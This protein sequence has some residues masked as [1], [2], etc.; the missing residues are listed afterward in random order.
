MSNYAINMIG[1]LG[2]VL[3]PVSQF[4]FLSFSNWSSVLRSQEYIKDVFSLTF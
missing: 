1:S 2:E 4:F 3:H